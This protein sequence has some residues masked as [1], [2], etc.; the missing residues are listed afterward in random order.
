MSVL[1]R[2]KDSDTRDRDVAVRQEQFYLNRVGGPP[3][4]WF[5]LPHRHPDHAPDAN[6]DLVRLVWT[7]PLWRGIPRP[8]FAAALRMSHLAAGDLDSVRCVFW[9]DN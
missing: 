3:R 4:D 9:F 8:F 1:Y 2:R 7:E 5:V 6:T